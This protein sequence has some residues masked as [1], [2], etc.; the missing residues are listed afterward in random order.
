MPSNHAHYYA[1]LAFYITNLKMSRPSRINI[2]LG[3]ADK[4]GGGGGGGGGYSPPA[5]LASYASEE[6]VC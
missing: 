6:L 5:P 1:N 2:F 3:L 4:M